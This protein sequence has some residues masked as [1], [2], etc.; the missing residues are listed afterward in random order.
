MGPAVFGGTGTRADKPGGLDL[1]GQL[2]TSYDDDV[3]ADQSG[4]R[5][6]RP[7]SADSAAGLYPGFSV[8]LQY[9][10]PGR[11]TGLNAWASNSVNYYP[12]LDDLTY[13]EL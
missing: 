10:R 8:G 13:N 7:R 2:F 4:R 3:L 12:D 6:H 5:T 9:S 11:S 1:Y